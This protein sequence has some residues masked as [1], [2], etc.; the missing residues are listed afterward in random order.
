M[1]KSRHTEDCTQRESIRSLEISQAVQKAHNDTM[2][3]EIKE[4]KTSI[5]SLDGKFDAFIDAADKKYATKEEVKLQIA[6]LASIDKS[7]I[8]EINSN[9]TSI[10]KLADWVAKYGPVVAIMAYI[11]L[12]GFI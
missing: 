11:L 9:K 2:A 3:A 4:V 5:K 8:D 12:G 1:V 10:A 7:L 6:N